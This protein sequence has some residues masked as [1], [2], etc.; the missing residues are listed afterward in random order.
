MADNFAK[1]GN[2][3]ALKDLALTL[4]A[5]TTDVENLAREV[6]LLKVIYKLLAGDTDAVDG[7][8][9]KDEIIKAINQV[10]TAPL[11]TSD[12]TATAADIAEGKTAYVNGV[13]ITGTAVF[14][15]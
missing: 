5:E 2:A 13:K 6:S 11:D 10:A 14:S 15:A 9:R 1:I 12:A 4:G 8:Q 7:L 3:G